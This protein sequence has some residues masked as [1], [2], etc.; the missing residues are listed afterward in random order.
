MLQESQEGFWILNIPELHLSTTLKTPSNESLSLQI[1]ML[2]KFDKIIALIWF[3]VFFETFNAILPRFI[4]YGIPFKHR[5]MIWSN[6]VKNFHIFLSF[7]LNNFLESKKNMQ[8]KL[9]IPK[10]SKAAFAI[11][12]GESKI[13]FFR[14]HSF[15]TMPT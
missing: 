1:E 10:R 14:D 13:N 15:R 12:W 3:R 8:E 5:W 2:S 7:K 11:K 6:F 9:T 4:A